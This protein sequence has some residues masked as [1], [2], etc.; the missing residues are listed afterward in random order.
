[1]QKRC[2]WVF[3]GLGVALLGPSA[4]LYTMPS[5][6]TSFCT[7]GTERLLLCRQCRREEEGTSK[8]KLDRPAPFT[9]RWYLCLVLCACALVPPALC[10]CLEADP[11]LPFFSFSTF[12]PHIVSSPYPGLRFMTMASA[13]EEIASTDQ[14]P[15]WFRGEV[16]PP[17]KQDMCISVRHLPTRILPCTPYPMSFPLPSQGSLEAA[18]TQD[19]STGPKPQ[20]LEGKSQNSCLPSLGT[21]TPCTH[22]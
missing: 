17:P 21:D 14:P 8:C 10:L 2:D 12:S 6:H 7:A 1:M 16:L 15:Y 18:P 19:D 11:G 22:L 13:R 9:M 20:F 4:S 5:M 3:P